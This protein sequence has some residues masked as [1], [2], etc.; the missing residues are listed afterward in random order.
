MLICLRKAEI[1]DLVRGQFEIDLGTL[2]KAEYECKQ[3]AA[4]RRLERSRLEVNRRL[5]RH[6]LV[7]VAKLLWEGVDPNPDV[8]FS[9]D[10]VVS[11]HARP[12]TVSGE[13]FRPFRERFA[14]TAELEKFL[15]PDYHLVDKPTQTEHNPEAGWLWDPT[16]LVDKSMRADQISEQWYCDHAAGMLLSLTNSRER[17]YMLKGYGGYVDIWVKACTQ[18]HLKRLEAEIESGVTVSM[19]NTPVN[20]QHTRNYDR[21]RKLRAKCGLQKEGYGM[22]APLPQRVDVNDFSSHYSFEKYLE[23]N[24]VAAAAEDDRKTKIKA[25][26]KIVRHTC[27]GCPITGGLFYPMG[28]EGL[29]EHM[30]AAHP[31]EFWETDDFHVIG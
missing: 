4:K 31:R 12:N 8:Y 11:Y 30:R 19:A 2:L 6:K 23:M 9:A 29:L 16:I 28:L 7:Q 13:T 25:F 20:V 18:Y 15:F 27:V 17:N 22:M 14:P 1:D 10:G 5:V 21:I 3:V 26:N 24:R